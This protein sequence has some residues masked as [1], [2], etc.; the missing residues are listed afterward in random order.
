MHKS[1]ITGTCWYNQLQKRL[2][3]LEKVKSEFNNLVKTKTLCQNYYLI[4]SSERPF[5]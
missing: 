1:T 4:R 5:E 2:L 3:W